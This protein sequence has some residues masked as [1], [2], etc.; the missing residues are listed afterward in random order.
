[1][2]IVTFIINC[3][4]I[5]VGAIYPP[6]KKKYFDQ[7]KIYIRLIGTGSSTRPEFLNEDLFQNPGNMFNRPQIVYA[8][9]D[10]KLIFL[11]NS[12]H[13]AYNL[14]LL[15]SL[16]KPN[17]T[18]VPEIDSFKPLLLNTEISYALKFNDTFERR[19]RDEKSDYPA[20]KEINN[21]KL[22]LEYT[23]VKGTKFFTTFVNSLEE[24]NKNKFLKK[25]T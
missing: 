2:Q 5:I 14:N 16:K 23:N 7:P 12:E 9:W 6:L 13:T 1:M 4:K 10:R 24:Q 3:L 8:S 20:P 17:F 18:I 15:T 22:T 21:L 19:E 25:I 11:N